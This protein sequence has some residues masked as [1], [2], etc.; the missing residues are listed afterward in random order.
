MSS[1]APKTE[2]QRVLE[3]AKSKIGSKYAFTATGPNSFDCSGFVTYVYR[4]AGLIDRI[5][6]KRR[7]WPAISTGSRR[8]ARTGH[9]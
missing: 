3:I 1:P 7:R 9:R 8:R 4:E 6:G 5:G 2:L